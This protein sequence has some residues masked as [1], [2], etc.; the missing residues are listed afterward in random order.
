MIDENHIEAAVRAGIRIGEEAYRDRV[1]A[2]LLDWSLTDFV[3]EAT[4]KEVLNDI[5]CR[6][7]NWDA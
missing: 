3:E 2:L 6:L 1:I 7:E 4:P 5:I